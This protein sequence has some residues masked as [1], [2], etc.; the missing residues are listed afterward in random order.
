MGDF[1]PKDITIIRVNKKDKVK[2]R[3]W[4]GRK[5]QLMTKMNLGKGPGLSLCPYDFF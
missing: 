2:K 1:G 3:A 4:M 5:W